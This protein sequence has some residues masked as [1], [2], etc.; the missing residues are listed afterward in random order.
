MADLKAFANSRGTLLNIDPRRL[1][2]KPELNAR[3][4][5][6]QD[7][8]VHVAEIASSIAENGFLSSH[9]LEI[10]S[11]GDD[12]FVSDGH[13][14]LAAVMRCIEAGMEIETIPCVPEPRGTNDV[15]RILKQNLQNY[16]KRLTPIEEAHNIMRAHR[17]GCSVAEIARRLN[18]SPTYIAKLLDFN[19]APEAVQNLVRDGAVSLA[20]AAEAVREHADQA[21][22]VLTE[23]AAAAKAEGKAKISRKGISRIAHPPCR[24]REG[25]G[26]FLVVTFEGKRVIL[27]RPIW[28]AIAKHI[29]KACNE[30]HAT[31]VTI[32][33]A[34]RVVEGNT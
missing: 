26:G 31:P 17:L 23:A 7:N 8:L 28:A 32:E 13:C 1:K 19:S 9:P 30:E 14:R 33:S 34:N 6:D 2:V 5:G 27:G 12:V 22:Q 24:I 3:D 21:A 18:K 11:E 25:G 29:A 15:A 20:T 4:L 16:G 10:F